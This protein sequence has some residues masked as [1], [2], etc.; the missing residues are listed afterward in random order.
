MLTLV[1]NIAQIRDIL[2]LGMGDLPAGVLGVAELF[3]DRPAQAVPNVGVARHEE[4]GRA[5]QAGGGVAAGQEDVEHVI[6]QHLGVIV[7]GGQRFGEDVPAGLSLFG[8]VFGVDGQAHVVIDDLV[9]APVGLPEFLG[10]D[11][12]VEIDGPGPRR[13]PF[14]RRV[15]RLGEALAVS[16][17]RLA[18]EASIRGRA[19][20]ADRF[21]EEEVG[22][23][24]DGQKEEE[25]LDVEARPVLGDQLDEAGNVPIHE[26]EVGDLIAGEL[27]PEKTARMRPA[28]A[29]QREDAVAQEGVELAM[30]GA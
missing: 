17:G 3:D 28:G 25:M 5:E 1:Q 16:N 13:Q 23:R 29:I 22:G 19:H 9:D 24:V 12:P 15:E 21:T 18:Q 27:R 11:H 14:L 4:E 10:V 26:V 7:V 20:G 8:V 2:Q 30:A 6:A